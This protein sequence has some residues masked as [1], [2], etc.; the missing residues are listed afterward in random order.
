MAVILG[1][2]TV[3]AYAAPAKPKAAELATVADGKRLILLKGCAGCHTVPGVVGANG[4]YAPYLGG[5]GSRPRVASGA[6]PNSGPQ[7]LERWI[8]DPPALKPGTAMPKLGLSPP[9]AAAIES[10]LETLP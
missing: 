9:E 1:V 7:D 6:V 5:V 8:L 4:E 2:L 3:A 10:Y